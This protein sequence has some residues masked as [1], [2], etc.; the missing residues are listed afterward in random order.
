LVLPFRKKVNFAQPLEKVEPNQC[1]P[2]VDPNVLL[3]FF[4]KLNFGFTF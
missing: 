2:K 4:E 1:F 3:Y